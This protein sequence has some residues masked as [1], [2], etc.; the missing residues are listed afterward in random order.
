MHI[1]K[2]NEAMLS[3]GVAL[4]MNRVVKETNLIRLW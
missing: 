1:L 3:M 4:G 2:C